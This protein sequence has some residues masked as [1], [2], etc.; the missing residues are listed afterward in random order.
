MGPPAQSPWVLSLVEKMLENAPSVM[1]FF[2]HNPFPDHPPKYIRAWTYEYHFTDAATRA[3]SE[4]WWWRNDKQQ[5]L[6]PI[7][8]RAGVMQPAH[9]EPDDSRQSQSVVH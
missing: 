4:D 8:L 6:P 2:Q 7:M 5:W 3:K 1:P 9:L